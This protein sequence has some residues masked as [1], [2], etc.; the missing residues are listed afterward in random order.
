MEKIITESQERKEFKGLET[1][2]GM[3][4][5]GKGEGFL[6]LSKAY[7]WLIAILAT[8]GAIIGIAYFISINQSMTAL[9]TFGLWL[10]I[11]LETFR[12]K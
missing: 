11:I 3:G 9:G 5:F 1:K 10:L 2:E 6:G 7:N 8:F 12:E 4:L